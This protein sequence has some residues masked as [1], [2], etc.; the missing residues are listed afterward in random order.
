MKKCVSIILILLIIAGGARANITHFNN[1]MATFDLSSPKDDAGD[2]IKDIIAVVGLKP[3]FTVVTANIDNAAAL[4]YNGKR[5]IAYN[6]QF[7]ARLNA[8]AGNK[9]A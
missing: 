2:I 3:N 1:K 7:I 9:W 8:A 4:I 5:Y 6:P